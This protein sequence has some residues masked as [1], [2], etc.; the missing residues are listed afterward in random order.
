MCQL[1]WQK[2]NPRVAFLEASKLSLPLRHLQ[3]AL[4]L[5]ESELS[6][7]LGLRSAPGTDDRG[8]E[9]VGGGEVLSFPKRL[10]APAVS[11][12]LPCPVLVRC[13]PGVPVTPEPPTTELSS[14]C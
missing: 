9:R 3:V 11:Q 14:L 12:S 10:V 7:K 2:P 5:G 13:L 4:Y 1:L 8:T 6:L